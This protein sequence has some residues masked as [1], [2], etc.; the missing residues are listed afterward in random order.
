MDNTK[1]DPLLNETTEL[2]KDLALKT[3]IQAPTS[4]ITSNRTNIVNK[5]GI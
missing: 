1:L 5:R 2:V 3:N 4:I